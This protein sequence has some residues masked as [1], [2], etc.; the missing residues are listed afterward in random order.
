MFRSARAYTI[1][2]DSSISIT[3]S[4]SQS[5]CVPKIPSADFVNGPLSLLKQRTVERHVAVGHSVHREAG[6][7]GGSAAGAIDLT[8]PSD[9]FDGLVQGVDQEAGHPVL[10]EFG[11]R[12]PFEGDDR[13]A[14]SHRLDDGEAERLVEVDQMQQRAGLA[15]R[16]GSWRSTDRPEIRYPVA[17]DAR[18]D[19]PFEIVLV[20]DDAGH[21]QPPVR[22]ARRLDRLRRTL[23]GMNTAEEQQAFSAGRVERKVVER[24]AVVNGSGVV[25]VGWRLAS[26]IE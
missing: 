10:D 23:V 13:G 25:E 12:A 11:H 8:D 2:Q 20:L 17:V 18:G 21:D 22:T 4:I 1:S 24:N 7:D 9:G 19:P 14:A 3:S 16:P 15:K 5:L 26:L 6:L